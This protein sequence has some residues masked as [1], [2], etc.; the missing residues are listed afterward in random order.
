VKLF[1]HSS[2]TSHPVFVSRPPPH[3]ITDSIIGILGG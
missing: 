1:M 2:S 3:V